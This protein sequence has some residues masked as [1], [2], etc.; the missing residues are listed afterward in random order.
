ML[1]EESIFMKVTSITL[2]ILAFMFLY[3]FIN[4]ALIALSLNWFFLIMFFIFLALVLNFSTL[5]IKITKESIIVSYGLIK[6][7]TP[8]KNIKKTYHDNVSNWWYGGW[9]IR[10][11]YVK[12]RWR[13]VFNVYGVPRIV[14]TLRNG[15]FDEF[16]F[17][18]KKPQEVMSII[19]KRIT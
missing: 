10:L 2:F 12:K 6:Y 3:L 13:H 17:S 16:V 1:Y 9:G 11:G 4:L 14:L 7:T 15:T 18:T 19:K 8:F 5:R